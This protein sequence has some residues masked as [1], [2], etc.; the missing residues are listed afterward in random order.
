M[1]RK[2]KAASGENTEGWLT[3]YADLISL[4]LCFFVLMYAASTPDE[5]KMQW[6]LQAMTPVSGTIVNPV[7]IDDDPMENSDNDEHDFPA[8]ELPS[9]VSGDVPGVPGAMPLTFDDLF[10]W[11]SETIAANELDSVVTVDMMQGRMHIRFDSDVMFDADSAVL[12]PEGRRALNTVAPGIRAVN[13]YI[14]NVSV[15]GHTAP[16]PGGTRGANAQQLSANR[17]VAVLDHL[18]FGITPRM[19]DADKLRSRGLGPWEPHYPVDTEESRAKN[20]RV[21]LVV[22]RNDYQPDDTAVMLDSLTYDYELGPIP[23]GPMGG[24]SPVPADFNRVQQIR[25]RIMARYDITEEEIDDSLAQSGWG[26]DD[27]MMMIPGIPTLPAQA[28]DSYYVPAGEG[29]E[30]NNTQEE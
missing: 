24:R 14:Q 13:D 28:D 11:V 23:V 6:I 15:E 5:A 1:A 10:N 4:L 7:P 26:S 8:P 29:A 3:T 21:E 12:R 30:G 9:E 19:V 17:A 20:R 18:D 16:L 25:N 27:Y 22:T 2:K